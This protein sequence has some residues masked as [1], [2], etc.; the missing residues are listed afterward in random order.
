VITSTFSS[1]LQTV[2]RVHNEDNFSGTGLFGH[3]TFR[4][5]DISVTTFCHDISVHKELIIF[6][7]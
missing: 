5:G 3:G 1:L 7:Y 6:V 2:Q 4:S